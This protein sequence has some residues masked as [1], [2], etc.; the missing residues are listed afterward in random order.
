MRFWER[1][2][3]CPQSSEGKWFWTKNRPS[4]MV[5]P[6]GKDSCLSWKVS[7]D[8]T[9]AKTRNKSKKRKTWNP[10]NIG[11]N[12]M[13]RAPGPHSDTAHQQHQKSTSEA[14]SERLGEQSWEKKRF[15]RLDSMAKNLGNFIY[16]YK[17][18]G[19]GNWKLHEQKTMQRHSPNLSILKSGVIEQ[20]NLIEHSPLSDTRSVIT[21]YYLSLQWVIFTRP[22]LHE[23]T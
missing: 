16:I 11:A 5:N 12:P 17:W 4:V 22:Y 6:W 3:R 20:K 8:Y 7:W 1:R 15:Y 13:S 18:G 10:R 21:A 19:K 23:I 14:E 9:P 2:E